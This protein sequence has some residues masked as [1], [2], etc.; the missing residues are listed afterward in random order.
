MTEI[1]IV[2]NKDDC[3]T[4]AQLA[5]LIWHEHYTPIIGVDQVEY[6][7]TKFQSPEAISTQIEDGYMYYI[8]SHNQNLAGYLSIKK[9]NTSL[10]LSK[11]YV[12]K[13]LRGLGIG[14]T[15]LNF[16]EQEAINNRC[17]SITLTVNRHNTHSIKAY[18]KLG[19]IK[20]G[21]VVQDIGQGYVMDD[22]TME[23]FL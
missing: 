9:K 1:R 7:L 18:E 20:T 15:A 11:I 4:I 14:K 19:F 10:F 17:Q 13:D 21:T 16:I 3:H 5:N 8:I 6:M 2:K 22:Y 23:R 12:S